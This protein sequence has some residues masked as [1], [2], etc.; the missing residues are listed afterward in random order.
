MMPL[1]DDSRDRIEINDGLIHEH[2][3]ILFHFEISERKDEI[4]SIRQPERE[5]GVLFLV[6][7]DIHLPRTNISFDI[8]RVY[9]LKHLVHRVINDDLIP[10]EYVDNEDDQTI[11]KYP[12]RKK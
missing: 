3:S 2:H 6:T 4:I 9:V 7:N 10:I 8:H 1:L 5:K 12:M 11:P